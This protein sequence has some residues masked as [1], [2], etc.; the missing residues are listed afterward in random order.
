MLKKVACGI[1]IFTFNRIIQYPNFSN[2][3]HCFPLFLILLMFDSVRIF[4]MDERLCGMWVCLNQCKQTYAT[5]CKLSSYENTIGSAEHVCAL[6]TIK[7]ELLLRVVVVVVVLCECDLT[8]S[9]YL[10]N[11]CANHC[12]IIQKNKSSFDISRIICNTDDHRKNV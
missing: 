9:S 7:P 12:L 8:N 2:R 3:F 5:S 11:S 10:L 6:E 4:S 1:N